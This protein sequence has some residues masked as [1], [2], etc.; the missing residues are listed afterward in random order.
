MP[1]LTKIGREP[2]TWVL[3]WCGATVCSFGRGSST[4]CV[5]IRALHFQNAEG[6]NNK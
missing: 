6:A 3:G 1:F 5:P 2:N 4:E